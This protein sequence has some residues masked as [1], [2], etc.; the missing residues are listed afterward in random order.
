MPKPKSIRFLFSYRILH[1]FPRN[2]V[3]LR[4]MLLL[5]VFY[6]ACCFLML[7]SLSSW[8][9]NA[10]LNAVDP[11]WPVF[12]MRYFSGGEYV[13]MAGAIIFGLSCVC[14]PAI[15]WLRI[16]FAI[17]FTCLIAWTNSFGKINHDWHLYVLIGILFSFLPPASLKISDRKYHS[18][19][20]LLPL[21][22]FFAALITATTYTMSAM[23]KLIGVGYQLQA[24]EVHA[25][26]WLS[27]AYQIGAR[28][29]QTGDSSL[30]GYF[31]INHSW[32]AYPFMVA[33][34]CLQLFAVLAPFRPSL[35]I[36]FGLGLIGFHVASILTLN[37][38]FPDNCFLLLIFF[39][40]SPFATPLGKQTLLDLPMV[41]LILSK[42]NWVPPAA[43]RPQRK[44]CQ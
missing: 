30:L 36:L 4:S 42:L 34:I 12:W 31:F 19:K 40:L 21:Y 32:A 24:G 2:T 16:T 41:S 3:H 22:F 1:P 37:I 9:S 44:A 18:Q 43:P 28:L 6:A 8:I 5:R 14:I 26:H 20:E 27:P 15:R 23:W 13:L 7:Q 33:I 35:L 10:Q 11:L 25:F 39:V 17:L 38:N 29:S